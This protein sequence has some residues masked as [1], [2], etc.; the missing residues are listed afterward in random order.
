MSDKKRVL[1]FDVGI[2]N[3][4]YCL[5]ERDGE[6]FSIQKWGIINLVD[7]RQKCNFTLRGGGQCEK[8]AKF[9][10]YHKEDLVIFGDNANTCACATHKTKSI[11]VIVP[12]APPKKK[13]GETISKLKCMLCDKD[14]EYELNTNSK[15]CW[16]DAHYQKNGKAFEKKI[17]C[18]KITV[19]NCNKQ[20]IQELT[21]KLV[22]RLDKEQF[23][24]VDE[25]L[26]ENQP[27]LKNPTMKTIASILYTYFVIRGITDKERTKSTINL[28]KFVSAS[29]KLKVD[30]EKTAEI[31]IKDGKEKTVKEQRKIY[32]LT[33]NLGK[34]YCTALIEEKDKKTLNGY[35]KIDDL[36][37]SF[38]QGFQYLF[39]K[40]P[41]VYM[42]KLRKVGET[43]E[44]NKT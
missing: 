44:K 19:Q 5:L 37:D 29:N 12:I 41:D 22:Q 32:D 1:S 25:V 16:C 43:V 27:S 13:K 35:K 21:E 40:I 36:C 11:P 24:S 18:R 14:G 2:L 4:A 38:L 33:K 17:V 15:Y 10:I 34:K 7:D 6:N 42:E 23:V 26:I 8:N 3:L 20:P 31:I 30:K 28:V 39:P 9:N